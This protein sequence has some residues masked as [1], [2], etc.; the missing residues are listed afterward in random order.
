VLYLLNLDAL[1]NFC[2]K[3]RIIVVINTFSIGNED[4]KNV[5]EVIRVEVFSEFLNA[6]RILLMR[7]SSKI[8]TCFLHFAPHPPIKAVQLS[9][10]LPIR[11]GG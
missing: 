11:I 9:D 3:L 10:G 7:F 4:E 8:P 2:P 6:A 5:S 1:K